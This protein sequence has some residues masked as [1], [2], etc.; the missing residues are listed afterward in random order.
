MRR[1][2]S[3]RVGQTRW[4]VTL[5][6][7]FALVLAAVIYIYPFLIELGT[8]FKTDDDATAH[9]LNPIPRT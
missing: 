9:P 2:P 8:S 3:Y 4:S 1:H 6:T 7:Y 5:A